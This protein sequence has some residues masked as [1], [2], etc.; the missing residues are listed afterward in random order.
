MIMYPQRKVSASLLLNEITFSFVRS[1]GAG[2]QHV[3][4]VSTK[5]ILKFDVLNSAILTEEEK[6]ILRT[7]LQKNITAAGM[8]ILASQEKRSQLQNKE[9]AIEKFDALIKKAFQTRKK[10]KATKPGKGAVEKRITNKKK[11]SEKK[12]NRRLINE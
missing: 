6:Q 12:N 9:I 1:S 11:H 2:G 10:R 3:N 7:K 8:L 5:V 4:K